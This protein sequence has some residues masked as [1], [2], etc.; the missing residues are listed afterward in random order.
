MKLA[1][2]LTKLFFIALLLMVL[3]PHRALLMLLMLT[4]AGASW[5]AW[6][7]ED[8]CQWTDKKLDYA[9]KNTFL[10]GK[11]LG[12]KLVKEAND[13]HRIIKKESQNV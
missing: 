8:L 5:I 3:N 12:E 10:L 11:G 4:S 9:R 13:I 2:K 7:L 6:R 1:G